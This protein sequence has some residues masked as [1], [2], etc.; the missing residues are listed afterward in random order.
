MNCRHFTTSSFH[1]AAFGILFKKSMK[2][3]NIADS[4]IANII[5][6]LDVKC[7]TDGVVIDYNKAYERIDK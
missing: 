6:M 3:C 1:G 2:I 4:R 7:S 5:S